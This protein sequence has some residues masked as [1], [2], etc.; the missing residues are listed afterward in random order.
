MLLKSNNTT[1]QIDSLIIQD[2][3]YLFEIK[4]Y[5]GDYYFEADNFYSMH[6]TKIQ[7]PLHQLNRCESLLSQLLLK[8]GYRIRIEAWVVF[9][10]PAFTLYQ[11]P[12][13]KPII[14]PTQLDFLMNKLN[15]STM[16]LNDRHHKIADLLVS[17]L[18]TESP[19]TDLPNYD[20]DK[21]QKG[22]TCKACHSFSIS[23][24]GRKTL[25]DECGNEEGFEAAV[26][27]SVREL[28]L[29]FPDR[30]ITTND[31][32]N[33][34]EMNVAQAR[35]SRILKKNLKVIGYGQWSTYE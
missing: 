10:N 30:K 8:H 20:F 27:R 11:A 12:K 26:M 17:L 4:N 16:K 19:Y 21:I 13:N 7:N 33:W 35:I 23:V 1:F 18:Q 3:L 9:I 6:E 32:L 5:E 34:C 28:K 24:H 29:L 2:V 31:V 14:Y 22:L 25:C 15:A